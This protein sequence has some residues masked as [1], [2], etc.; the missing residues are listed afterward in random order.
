MGV[1]QRNRPIQQQSVPG[2]AQLDPAALTPLSLLV[3]EVGGGWG[4]HLNA[5]GGAR[6]HTKLP[7]L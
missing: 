3:G 2:T 6:S 4:A 7:T 1:G 5:F